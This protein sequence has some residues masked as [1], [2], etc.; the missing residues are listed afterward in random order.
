LQLGSRPKEG[1]V[2]RNG[3]SRD[4]FSSPMRI[5]IP[6]QGSL[7][8]LNF[9]LSM[10][11]FFP[12]KVDRFEMIFHP[13]MVYLQPYA[14]SMLAAWGDYWERQG[15]PIQFQNLHS[16]SLAYAWR[17]GLFNF[18]RAQYEPTR[19]EHEEAGRFIPLR[20]IERSSELATFLTDLAPLLHR[21]EHVQAVQYCLSETIRNVLEHS[22]GSPAFVCAQYYREANRVS[23]GVADCGIG[24]RKS[25]STN[26]TLTSDSH[27]LLEAMKPGVT[28]AP[29]GMY[30]T[31]DNAGA[32]LF[33]TK[34]IAKASHEY[35]AIISGT[36]AFRLRRSR[37]DQPARL[38]LDPLH[39]RHDLYKGLPRWCGTVAAADIG[40]RPDNSF[41]RIMAAIRE[42]YASGR[43]ARRHFPTI[44]F[45]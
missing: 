13:Q 36:A 9:F 10:N 15:V 43:P 16:T 27:A 4:K 21:P 33:F 5:H 26:Y 2:A 32:G 20:R 19:E 14:L 45:T 34:S 39:D 38:Y 22:G 3:R 30:G 31:V 17:M 6:N 29:R 18:L 41:Q 25:L 1:C 23:I 7:H 12:R 28:G 42:A 37:P 11:N 8:C 24:V 35:F 40:I 44:R